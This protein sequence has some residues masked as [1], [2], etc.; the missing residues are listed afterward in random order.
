MR[1]N[2]SN[3]L[4][5]A[6]LAA[7]SLLFAAVFAVLLSTS[8]SQRPPS[9]PTVATVEGQTS[10][11]TAESVR[12]ADATETPIPVDHT[13]V[14]VE[15]ETPMPQPIAV[16]GTAPAVVATRDLSLSRTPTIGAATQLPLATQPS[17]DQTEIAFIAATT[18]L[19]A[20]ASATP[21]P[22]DDLPTATLEEA[23]TGIAPANLTLTAIRETVA[24]L[25]ERS[26]ARVE[27]TA[28]QIPVYATGTPLATETAPADATE[29]P[30]SSPTDVPPTATLEEAVTR[31]APANLT[32]TAIRETVV[33]LAARSTARAE[34]T[35]TPKPSPTDV[36]PTATLEEA[37]TLIAPANLTLT[38]IRETVVALAE[39]STARVEL[40]AELTPVD[41]TNTPLATETAPADATETPVPSPT[42]VVAT[43]TLDESV[44][45]IAPANLTLTAIRETVVA[46]AARTEATETPK[47]S[48]TDVPPTA[49]L[50]EAATRIAPAN[51]TLTAIR[52]T[53][54]AV[55]ERSTERAETTLESKAADATE[56]PLATE[57]APAD[58]T[59]TPVPS[60][61]DVVATAT[62]E[63]VVTG[64]APANLTLTAIRET[65]AALAERSN[66]GDGGTDSCRCN[67]NASC[68]GDSGGGGDGNSEVVTDGCPADSDA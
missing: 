10:T 45:G 27:L 43:A 65:V 12:L 62:P 51:L 33:A 46:L 36:P 57:T 1:R 35:E 20:A 48:P 39:R 50:E 6:L 59:E 25:A 18:T 53:I 4:I 61:T 11:L 9:Q 58:A 29:T 54:D 55:A 14:P 17:A 67:R 64:L 32:L 42:D 23:A 63:K 5:V 2:I 37:A 15:S 41:A 26:T 66:G 8:T 3:E 28:E 24:A 68:N 34:A 31:I 7:V 22:T 56:P 38:A 13:R 60:P 40:T 52:E 16:T 21:S 44:T 19:D 30:K 49:T 47:P